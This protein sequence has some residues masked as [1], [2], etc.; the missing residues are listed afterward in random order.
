M[1]RE[2]RRVIQL[3]RQA[4][5]IKLEHS[6]KLFSK[7]VKEYPKD[8]AVRVILNVSPIGGNRGKGCPTPSV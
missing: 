5:V 4:P 1:L 6:I 3:L 7:H 2:P 8:L